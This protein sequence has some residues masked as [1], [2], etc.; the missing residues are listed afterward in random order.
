MKTTF[1]FLREVHDM[2]KV[3]AKQAHRSMAKEL[4]YLIRKEWK[5]NEQAEE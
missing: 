4:E 1:H 2:L 5:N 3:L